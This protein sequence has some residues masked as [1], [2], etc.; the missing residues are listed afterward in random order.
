MTIRQ[1]AVLCFWKYFATWIT[2]SHVAMPLSMIFL[3][4]YYLKII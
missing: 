2:F 1:G 3:N 4:K